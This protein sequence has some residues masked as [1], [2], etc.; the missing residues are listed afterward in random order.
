[1]STIFFDGTYETPLSNY[2]ISSSGGGQILISSPED[3]TK[4]VG[5]AAPTTSEVWA[6]TRQ[7][8]LVYTK[9]T[10]DGNTL[11]I[12]NFSWISTESGQLSFS[13]EWQL[14]SSTNNGNFQYIN[15]PSQGQTNYLCY[16]QGTGI[17]W[18]P[19]VNT[20]PFAADI[21]GQIITYDAVNNVA[22]VISSTLSNQVLQGSN[23]APTGLT[24]GYVR[25]SNLDL[26][27]RIIQGSALV[28]ANSNNTFGLSSAY[29]YDYELEN[30]QIAYLDQT[31]STATIRGIPAPTDINLLLYTTRNE[32]NLIRWTYGHLTQQMAGL[33]DAATDGLLAG[34]QNGQLTAVRDNRPTYYGTASMSGAIN[35]SITVPT[36]DRV[37]PSLTQSFAGDVEVTISFSLYIPEPDAF[38]IT[39]N[40]LYGICISLLVNNES[41]STT[42]PIANYPILSNASLYYPVHYVCTTTINGSVTGFMIS[43]TN[44]PSLNVVY[45]NPTFQLELAPTES[46]LFIRS[47]VTSYE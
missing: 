39:S 32:F 29:G 17:Q 12:D 33:G 7:L 9:P 21:K 40:E 8:M 13:Q 26:D 6:N 36:T 10:T 15:P 24:F 42:V 31:E 37:D 3:P 34:W 11:S 1:M 27:Y 46:N 30:G 18:T 14:L 35:D 44:D 19:V 41:G 16:V 28:V 38:F 4:F 45:N 22:T 43:L 47:L 2:T 5:I 23:T 25:P 20:Y